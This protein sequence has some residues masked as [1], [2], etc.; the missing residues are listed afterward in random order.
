M[1]HSKIILAYPG[2]RARTLISILKHNLYQVVHLDNFGYRDPPGDYWNWKISI[3]V[4]KSRIAD[5]ELQKKPILFIGWGTNWE[6][7]FLL[8]DGNIG[9]LEC[10]DEVYKKVCSNYRQSEEYKWDQKLIANSP[11]RKTDYTIKS[12]LAAFHR[13]KDKLDDA[14]HSFGIQ[15]LRF[16]MKAKGAT[17]EVQT[18]YET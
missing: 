6:K 8:C 2:T 3:S 10:E 12:H 4:L 5:A 7:F 15:P 9:V 17:Y 14:C 16:H 18:K 13:F 11:D 1:I